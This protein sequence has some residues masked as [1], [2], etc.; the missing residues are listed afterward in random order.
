MQIG[1]EGQTKM[2]KGKLGENW[3]KSP[4]GA[5]KYLGEMIKNKSNP[6]DHIADIAKKIK[7]TTTQILAEAGNNKFKA[8]RCLLCGSWYT[9]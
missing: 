6:V 4:P 3:G 5:Y 9:Q 8:L 1:E 7:V 2:A